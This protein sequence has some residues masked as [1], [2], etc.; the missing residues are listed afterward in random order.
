MP[1]GLSKRALNASSPASMPNLPMPSFVRFARLASMLLTAPPGGV[2]QFHP[3][4]PGPCLRKAT[5]LGGTTSV[6]SCYS[7]WFFDFDHRPPGLKSGE[8]PQSLITDLSQAVI[9]NGIRPHPPPPPP[10]F[11][12]SASH[13]RRQPPLHSSFSIMLR[14]HCRPASVALAPSRPFYSSLLFSSLVQVSTSP[15]RRIATGCSIFS[16]ISASYSAPSFPAQAFA[17]GSVSRLPLPPGVHCEPTASQ[18]LPLR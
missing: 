18:L 1:A 6:P 2:Q 13:S 9:L 15:H 5:T 12:R 14:L 8:L 16:L 10:I 11:I 4:G 7:H 17:P 3:N